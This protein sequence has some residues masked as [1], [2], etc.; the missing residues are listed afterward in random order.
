[1]IINISKTNKHLLNKQINKRL[2]INIAHKYTNSSVNKKGRP[3]V[4]VKQAS[5]RF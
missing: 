2:L 4:K 3:N 5:K 1:M